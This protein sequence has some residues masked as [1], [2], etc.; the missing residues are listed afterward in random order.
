[1][2]LLSYKA[3][4][5]L[6]RK[7]NLP[8]FGETFPCF[9]LVQFICYCSIV[10]CFCSQM[11]GCIKVLKEQPPDTVEGLLNALRYVWNNCLIQPQQIPLIFLPISLYLRLHL[12]LLQK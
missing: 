4:L 9:Q 7:K 12:D 11:K 5:T 3:A 6:S 8:V 1:M 10:A 2:L